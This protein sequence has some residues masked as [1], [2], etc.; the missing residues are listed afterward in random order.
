MKIDGVIISCY[1]FDLE[2]TRIFVASLRFFIY[3]LWIS[4]YAV[5]RSCSGRHTL[6]LRRPEP[7]APES[8]S[9]FS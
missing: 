5:T 3:Y 8:T 6:R 9:S 2:W 1:R 7:F 4:L